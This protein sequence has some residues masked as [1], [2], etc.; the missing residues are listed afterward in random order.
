M[1]KIHS[2]NDFEDL[3][4]GFLDIVDIEDVEPNFV[5]DL[6]D[7]FRE[8]K[9]E[10]SW[11][12]LNTENFGRENSDTCIELNFHDVK[13]IIKKVTEITGNKFTTLQS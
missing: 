4:E 5:K 10:E 12:H 2:I 1:I 7:S 8:T 11:L 3:L 13:E 9:T 6:F